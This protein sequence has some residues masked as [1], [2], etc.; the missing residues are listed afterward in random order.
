MRKIGLYEARSRFAE[1]VSEASRGKT[2]LLTKNGQ[3]IAQLSAVPAAAKLDTIVEEIL[4]LPWTLGES[5]AALIRSA[6]ER[7]G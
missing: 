6:R 1:I 7:R 3:P 5:P 4:A 2:V